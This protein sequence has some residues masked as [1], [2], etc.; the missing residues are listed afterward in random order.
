MSVIYQ[1]EPLLQAAR[2]NKQI[3]IELHDIFK[4]NLGIAISHRRAVTGHQVI[5][6]KTQ[7]LR[8]W[9]LLSSLEELIEVGGYDIHSI[10]SLKE[11]HIEWMVTHWVEKKLSYGC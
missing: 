1:F 7:E 10:Y 9:N 5:S 2:L 6:F 4:R 3:K 11:K 8:C